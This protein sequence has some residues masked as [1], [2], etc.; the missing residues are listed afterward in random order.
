MMARTSPKR[1]RYIELSNFLG[2][3]FANE[4]T[5]VDMRRSPYAPNMVADRAGRPEKR[6]GYQTIGTYNGRINGI[7]FFDGKMIVHAGTAFYD[8]DGAVLYEGANDERSVSFIMGR[9]EVV[10]EITMMHY[11]LY[12]LDG[13]NYLRYDGQTMEKV[14]GYIPTTQAVGILLEPVNLLQPKRRNTFAGDGTKVEFQLDGQNLDSE[15]SVVYVDG[16]LKQEGA[17]YTINR[18]EGTIT[19]ASAPAKPSGGENISVQFSR[20]VPGYREMIEKCCTHST[21]G[22]GNDTRVFVTGNA[23]HPN[24]DWQ[25]ATYNPEYFPDTGYT[26]LGS[27]NTAI[28]GYMKQYDSMIVVKE[29]SDE[30]GLFL[31]SAQLSETEY[32]GAKTYEPIFPV[33]EGISGIGAI[34]RYAFAGLGNDQLMLT[35]NG[36]CGLSTNAVSNQKS[37]VNRSFMVNP[38]LVKEKDLSQAVAAVWGRFYVLSVNGVCYVANTEQTC[39]TPSGTGYEWYYW[40]DIPARVLREHQGKLYFGTETGKVMCFKN[41]EKEGRFAFS[42]D[43]KPINSIWTTALL[44]GGNFMREKS[45]A[46]KGTGVLVKPYTRSSGEIYFTTDKT[47]R[48][49]TRD[50]TMDIFDFDDVDFNRFTFDIMDGPRVQVSPR[51]FR[52]VLQFQMGVRNNEADQGFGILAMMISFTM[53]NLTRRK[54]G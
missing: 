1:A 42:D 35:G 47:L 24:R 11:S 13:A 27:G 32:E 4:E 26:D 46:K 29:Q 14:E 6:A 7:H 50:F 10:D 52:K 30:T 28:M 39:S 38:Q 48:E 16:Q 36:V 33:K 37:V 15:A 21:F 19:F 22:V 17:D 31:R 34:S 9:R 8:A 23:E 51:K 54:N 2:V 20:T 49:V 43:G 5:E 3:D 53:G 18:K 41:P 12:L 25:S 45:I 40:T 44:D